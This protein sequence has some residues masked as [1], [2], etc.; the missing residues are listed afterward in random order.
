VIPDPQMTQMT[1]MTQMNA[2]DF[3][4]CPEARPVAVAAGVPLSASICA[5]CG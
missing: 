2:D 4:A 5:I 3:Y 1:Q